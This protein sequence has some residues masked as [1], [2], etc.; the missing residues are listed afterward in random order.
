[1]RVSSTTKSGNLRQTLPVFIEGMVTATPSEVISNDMLGQLAKEAARVTGVLE[2]RHASPGMTTETLCQAAAAKLMEN[3][4]TRPEDVA[5]LVYVTQT[6]GRP[7]PSSAHDLHARLKLP[8]MTPAVEVNWSCSGYVYG[9][10]LA[11]V[12]LSQLSGNGKALVLVGDT[13]ST[14]VDQSDRATGPLFGDA[15]SATLLAMS[16]AVHHDHTTFGEHITF[17]LG[18]NGEGAE[19]LSRRHGEALG[20]DGTKVMNFALDIVP[21][22][23]EDLMY[24]GRPR[25][26]YFHQANQLIIRHLAKKLKLEERLGTG[27]VPQNVERFGNSSCASIPLLMCDKWAERRGDEAMMVGFGAGWAWAGA[28]F[29]TARIGCAERIEL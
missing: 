19:A 16:G 10:W 14:V 29:S 27:S 12:I 2:R 22:L 1:M 15:G 28:V 4:G 17:V 26:A 18:N 8:A 25:V 11:S 6:P 9:L 21:P 7:L 24:C 5:V 3:L 13:I 23:V 20:M